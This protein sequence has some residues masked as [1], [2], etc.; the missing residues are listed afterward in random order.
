MSRLQNIASQVVR[1]HRSKDR[2][3]EWQTFFLDNFLRPMDSFAKIEDH[4][5]RQVEKIKFYDD[6]FEQYLLKTSRG[7][8][9]ASIRGTGNGTDGT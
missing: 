8:C 9:S 3:T 6:H 7:L 2:E 5:P 4:D 1:L